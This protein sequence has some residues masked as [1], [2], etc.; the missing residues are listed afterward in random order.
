MIKKLTVNITCIHVE[1]YIMLL[2]ILSERSEGKDGWSGSG[3]KE[4]GERNKCEEVEKG[5]FAAHS[6]SEMWKQMP[7][8]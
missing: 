2:A 6:L 1:H 8:C 7:A 5:V 4:V 3:R